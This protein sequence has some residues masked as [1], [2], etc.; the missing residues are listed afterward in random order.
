M[1]TIEIRSMSASH[2]IRDVAEALNTRFDNK[3]KEY[4]VELPSSVG[5]GFITGIDTNSGLGVLLYDCTFNEDVEIC[6]SIDEVHPLK[7]LYVLKGSMEHR[8]EDDKDKPH[9]IA[10]YQTAIVA[11]KQKNG[12]ILRFSANNHVRI[13][14]LE[15]NRESFCNKMG[16]DLENLQG[17]MKTVFE[18]VE[19]ENNFYYKDHFSLELADLFKKM[20]DFQKVDYLRKIYLEGMAYQILIKQIVLFIDYQQ[21]ESNQRLLR[22]SEIEQVQRAINY[23]EEHIAE[24]PQVEEIAREVGLNV[25]KL[26]YGFKM[27]HDTTVN[28]FIHRTRLDIA[29]NLLLH[30][31]FNV[32][33]VANSVGLNNKSYFSK[34]FK[35]SYRITPSEFKQK[36]RARL[37]KMNSKAG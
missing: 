21:G 30:T 19:A 26:Q 10:E 4:T 32:S 11:S 14:S 16:C 8:F 20:Y 35:E 25:N 15:I 23:I 9:E 22:T 3:C 36:N 7:F 18:D 12:H 2:I 33:D 29:R 17:E 5:S 34:V 1:N 37:E 28:K 6:F 31:D 27:L 24:T 13:H